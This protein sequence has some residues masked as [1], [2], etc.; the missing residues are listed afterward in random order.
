MAA[1]KVQL[2]SRD[3]QILPLEEEY[4]RMARHEGANGIPDL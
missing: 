1:R 2:L 3:G 4:H